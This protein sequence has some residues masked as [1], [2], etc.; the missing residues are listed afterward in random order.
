MK[1]SRHPI[2]IFSNLSLVWDATMLVQTTLEA[3]HH[4]TTIMQRQ[5]WQ[6]RTSITVRP[7]TEDT[8]S[9]APPQNY[10]TPG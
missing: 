8:G 10:H 2:F 1:Y 4:H 3:A 7:R 5:N 6:P 9:N